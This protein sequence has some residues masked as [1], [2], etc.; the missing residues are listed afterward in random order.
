MATKKFHIGDVLSVTTCQI[1]GPNKMDG[2]YK[3]L[4]HLCGEEIYTHQ[5]PRV[6]RQC[7]PLLLKQH[8]QLAAV[9]GSGVTA[10]TYQQWLA[11]V[12]AEF[13]EQLDIEPLAD[14]EHYSIDPLSELAEH[15]PP[16][17]IAALGRFN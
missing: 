2:L 9:T 13:G 16:N 15:V 3:I 8:P 1:L 4:K 5:L 10:D 14:G 7:G 6:M 17:R 12:V 11:G